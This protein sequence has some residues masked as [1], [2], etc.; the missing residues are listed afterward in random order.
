M[1]NI[2]CRCFNVETTE[3]ITTKMAP[4][5]ETMDGKLSTITENE[6]VTTE[7]KEIP[8]ST[9]TSLVTTLKPGW[10]IYSPF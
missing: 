6:E 7:N 1:Y 2:C 3:K 9:T 10:G 8:V 4:I 5:S